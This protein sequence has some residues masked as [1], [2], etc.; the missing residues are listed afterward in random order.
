MWLTAA[1]REYKTLCKFVPLIHPLLHFPLQHMVPSRDH[2]VKKGREVI[3]D[4]KVRLAILSLS[5]LLTAREQ[6]CVHRGSWH[7][8][9]QGHSLSTVEV[10]PSG[11]QQDLLFLALACPC[12]WASPAQ[13]QT[14]SAH[15][16]RWPWTNGPTRTPWAQGTKRRERR[17]RYEHLPSAGE[18]G[19]PVGEGRI[20][21]GPAWLWELMENPHGPSCLLVWGLVFV[22]PHELFK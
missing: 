6:P 9:A 14:W 11:S 12:W 7:R 20:P 3:L 5:R 8:A 10:A 21:Q 18:Q 13:G 2:P 1:L 15:S 22:T 4:P 16:L 19:L 17:E